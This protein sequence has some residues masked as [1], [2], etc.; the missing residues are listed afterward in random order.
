MTSLISRNTRD[1]EIIAKDRSLTAIEKIR[2]LNLA[3]ITEVRKIWGSQ[4]M[5]L[6]HKTQMCELQYMCPQLKS[7]D[8]C[9]FSHSFP[10]LIAARVRYA[11][12]LYG[13]NGWNRFV[14]Y[15]CQQVSTC[16]NNK[17]LFVHNNEFFYDKQSDRFLK[18]D[19]A[20]LDKALKTRFQGAW[21]INEARV[22]E[23]MSKWDEDQIG[24]LYKT[25]RCIYVLN[26]QKGACPD[27]MGCPNAHSPLF[28]VAG[29]I[30]VA[31]SAGLETYFYFDRLDKKPKGDSAAAASLYLLPGEYIDFD[32]SYD[33]YKI[34][35]RGKVFRVPALDEAQQ[36]AQ[37]ELLNNN[38]LKQPSKGASQSPSSSSSAAQEASLVLE[39]M[40]QKRLNSLGD[41]IPSLE[42]SSPMVDSEEASL[43]R[44]WESASS[45]SLGQN[46]SSDSIGGD[47]FLDTLWRNASLEAL[48]QSASNPQ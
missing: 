16:S 1:A 24:T 7:P 48:G 44:L 12:A 26:P 40:I 10:A 32:P 6:V 2:P 34:D 11:V 5:L 45:N 13:E 3:V 41:T 37:I 25:K 15:P 4:K 35:N 17:C 36:K 14:S 21:E 46:A 19:P 28:L 39:E 29:R 20:Y 38:S 43:K 30:R 42:S 22:K 18:Y 31:L 9:S 27:G 47:A 8:G 23:L 33:P